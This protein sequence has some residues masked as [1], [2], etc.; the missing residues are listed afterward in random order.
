MF[1]KVHDIVR[2]QGVSGLTPAE[3]RVCISS[4]SASVYSRRA[5]P[6]RGHPHL[7]KTWGD[8]LVPLT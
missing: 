8:L 4:R 1:Y 3:H 7:P 6:L 2:A 5:Y